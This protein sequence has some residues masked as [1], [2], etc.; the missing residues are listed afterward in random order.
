MTDLDPADPDVGWMTSAEAAARLGVKPQTLYAYVS[1]G[2]LTSHRRPGA[3]QSRFD[4]TEVERLAHRSARAPTGQTGGVDIEVSSSL[5]L[6]DPGGA[7]YYR[8]WDA[9]AAATSASYERVAEWLWTASAA[10]PPTWEAPPAVLA[11]A[12]AVQAGLPPEVSLTD[13]VRV[14][15]AAA[16]ATDPYR[17]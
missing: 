17:H 11:A 7:L 5:T 1:R 2:L 4:R 15:T 3:R 13:R 14:G 12:R 16:G 9:L 8:G 10:E 6:L